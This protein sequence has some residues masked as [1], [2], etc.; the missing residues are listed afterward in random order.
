LFAW[1]APSGRWQRFLLLL[2]AREPDPRENPAVSKAQAHD[3]R[4]ASLSAHERGGE[5]LDSYARLAGLAGRDVA[6]FLARERANV[7]S[8]ADPISISCPT[9]RRSR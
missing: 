7:T 6:R 9:A 2:I 4:I 1:R 5:A 8:T 3:A